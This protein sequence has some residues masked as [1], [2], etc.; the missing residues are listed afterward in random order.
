MKLSKEDKDILLHYKNKPDEADV[1]YKQ[2]I[3]EKLLKN[4]RIIYLLNNKTLAD[5]DAENDEYFGIN[6]LPF[7]LI[8]PVQTEVNNY[9]CFECSFTE[10]PRYNSALKVQ[11]IIFYILCNYK[12]VIEETT[13]CPRHD[14]LAAEI[15]NDFQGCNDFGNQLKLISDR[16]YTTDNDFTMRTLVFEQITPNSLT[17]NKGRS[18]NL[19]K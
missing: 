5:S 15:I 4:N 19:R 12:T 13:T 16:P 8:H 11:Q 6:I 3:K 10:E 1:R 17:D 14:L 18:F 7:Y 2:I 9:I